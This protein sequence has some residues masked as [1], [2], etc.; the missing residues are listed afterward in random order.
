MQYLWVEASL[1]PRLFV[2]GNQNFNSS[3]GMLNTARSQTF[4]APNG[5]PEK[6]AR[7]YHPLPL[8]HIE[9]DCLS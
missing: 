9:W 7:R 5:Q 6:G 2:D 3:S 8:P 1:K 4:A